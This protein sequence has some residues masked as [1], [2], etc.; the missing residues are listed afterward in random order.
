MEHTQSGG[1]Y[2]ARNQDVGIFLT[3]GRPLMTVPLLMEQGRRSLWHLFKMAV[4]DSPIDSVFLYKKQHI[5]SA[6]FCIQNKF[7]S[8]VLRVAVPKLFG[9]PRLGL[10]SRFQNNISQFFD[11]IL[12]SEDYPSLFR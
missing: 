7:R 4:A 10:I 3:R 8:T 2:Y 6:A 1:R 5:K 11:L 9:K 12:R